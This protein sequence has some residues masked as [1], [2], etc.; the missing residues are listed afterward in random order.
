VYFAKF[1]LVSDDISLEIF[2][3]CLL[4]ME[5]NVRKKGLPF[6]KVYPGELEI[7]VGFG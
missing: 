1:K 7:I 4:E 6:F 3:S 2:L 5:T